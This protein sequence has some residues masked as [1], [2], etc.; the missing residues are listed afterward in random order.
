ME[1]RR[2]RR[3]RAS[4]FLSV[5]V[6]IVPAKKFTAAKF[7]HFRKK[8]APSRGYS[9]LEEGKCFILYFYH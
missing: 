4:L 3:F 8:P 1:R 2:R 5:G 6:E 7:F 9:A